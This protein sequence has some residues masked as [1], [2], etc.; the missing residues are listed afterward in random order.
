[1]NAPPK[2]N[3]R[4]NGQVTTGRNQDRRKIT[5]TNGVSQCTLGRSLFYDPLTGSIRLGDLRF[6][7]E[8]K[9][10][11]CLV[12]GGSNGYPIQP[13]RI[14]NPE[15]RTLVYGG[16][17]WGNWSKKD[18]IECTHRLEGAASLVLLATLENPVWGQADYLL[19][20]TLERMEQ[21]QQSA[22]GSGRT[23]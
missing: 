5:T 8:R 6:E 13:H 14:K 12:M 21:F 20:E 19:F 1:M 11:A 7:L 17:N 23:L 16:M 2:E 22:W 9:L 4:G 10:A 3:A 18:L 15:I